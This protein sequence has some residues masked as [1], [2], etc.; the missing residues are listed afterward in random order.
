MFSHPV[1]YIFLFLSVETL[2]QTPGLI[3]ANSCLRIQVHLMTMKDDAIVTNVTNTEIRR[4]RSN[5]MYCFEKKKLEILCS[6]K[7][8]KR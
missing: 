8:K 4:F 5:P 3:V 2:I 7:K 6:L 1:R